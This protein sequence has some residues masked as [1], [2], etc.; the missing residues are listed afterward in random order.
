MIVNNLKDCKDPYLG[1]SIWI[2]DETSA[3]FNSAWVCT[4]LSFSGCCDANGVYAPYTKIN[5]FELRDKYYI[6]GDDDHACYKTVYNM[7]ENFLTSGVPEHLEALEQ[8]SKSDVDYVIDGYFNKIRI[9]STGQDANGVP[10]SYNTKIR[11]TFRW[12]WEREYYYSTNA[13]LL[14]ATPSINSNQYI[15]D[16]QE[17]GVM[18]ITPVFKDIRW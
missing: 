2:S 18:S 4:L 6:D 17:I 1:K 3:G 16:Y 11:F 9:V 8:Y 13:I 7:F 14:E 15:S 10:S 12:D 5:Y